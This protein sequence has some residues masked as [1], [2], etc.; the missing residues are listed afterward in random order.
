MKFKDWDA[1]CRDKVLQPTILL[2]V[3]AQEVWVYNLQQAESVMFHL[4]M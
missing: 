3:L 2:N 1:Y 4:W